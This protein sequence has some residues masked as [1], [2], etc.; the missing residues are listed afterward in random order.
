MFLP[1]SIREG[2]LRK[3]GKKLFEGG[4]VWFGLG[5][6]G[7]WFGGW[8]VGRMCS[9]WRWDGIGWEGMCVCVCV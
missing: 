7:G 2:G 1:N 5:W 3:V 6:F 4:L 9:L 8:F